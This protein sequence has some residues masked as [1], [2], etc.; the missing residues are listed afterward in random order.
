M[1]VRR[2]QYASDPQHL[3]AIRAEVR[4]ACGEAWGAGAEEAIGLL[5]LAVDEAAA[6]VMRHAYG[7]RTDGVIELVVDADPAGVAVTLLHGGHHFDP[8]AVPP[9][10][11]DGS[12]TGGFGLYL[13]RT[14]VDEVR[15]F[16]EAGRCGVRLVKRRRKGAGVMQPE[17]EKVGD[18]AVVTPRNWTPAT[19]TTSGRTWPRCWRSTAWWS[20]TWA[21]CSSWTAAAAARSSRASSTCPRR[22]VT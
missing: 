15:H 20:S 11:F 2:S 17:V 16:E 12:R 3:A 5:E 9:P 18:V 1:T 13:M 8:A 21:G 22:G 7:G 19:P 4:A 14:A 10:S 6:N